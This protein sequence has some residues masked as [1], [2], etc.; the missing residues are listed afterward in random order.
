MVLEE[1]LQ[2]LGQHFNPKSSRSGPS[3]TEH[4]EFEFVQDLDLFLLR[5]GGA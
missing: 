3:Y 4:L 1:R 5:G 2:T